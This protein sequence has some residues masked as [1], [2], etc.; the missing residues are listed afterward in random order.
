MAEQ[1]F[2]LIFDGFW[3]DANI[4]KVPEKS[5]IY[6]AYTYTLDELN[7]KTKLTIHKLIFIGASDNANLTINGHEKS[8]EFH[9]YAGER[10]KI[11]YSFAPLNKEFREIVK[12]ALVV[13]HNPPANENDNKKYEFE[14]AQINIEGQNALLKREIIIEKRK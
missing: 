5:G 12:S 1:K 14:K 4:V 11:C 9:K 10:Q 6:C 2:K 8:G 7:K 3:R 13:T